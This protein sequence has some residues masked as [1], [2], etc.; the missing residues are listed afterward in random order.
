MTTTTVGELGYGLFDCDHHMYEPR[1]SFT[2]YIEPRLRDQAVRTVMK[3]GKE[4][5]MVGDR[6]MKFVDGYEVYDQ[7]GRPGSLKE[8]LYQMKSGVVNEGDYEWEPPRPEYHDRDQRIASLDEQGVEACLLFPSVAIVVEPLFDDTEQLYANYHAFNRWLEETWGFAYQDR[9]FAL[10]TISLRDRDKAVEELEWA[11]SKGVRAI[12]MRPGA[13]DG[14]AP[15]DPYF[16]PFW[17]RLNE[18]STTVA[19]HLTDSGYNR[20]VSTQWGEDG[21]PTNF[22]MSAWQ[23]TNCYGDRPIM[24]TLSAFIFDGLFGA[25]PNVKVVSVENGAEWA[26]Y[27]VRRMDK[28]KAMGRNGPWRRGRLDERPSEIWNRHVRVT[29][30]PEDDIPSIVKAMGAESLA[31]G[32]DWP[33]P[34]GTKLPG[35]FAELVKSLTANEQRL[36]LRDNGFDLI[37]N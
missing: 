4:I 6:P 33:H 26:P 23:W 25:F 3:E 9:I 2:R 34:E 27:I 37:S 7:V 18:A 17:A 13:V 24:D 28:M 11:L 12:S 32:S 30:F 5:L 21:D 29:P 1:D 15:S 8:M 20:N 14:R 31:M 35:D 19:L 16:D 22:G 36:I 10:P